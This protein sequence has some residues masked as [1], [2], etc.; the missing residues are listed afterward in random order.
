ML[1]LD[2]DIPCAPPMDVPPAPQMSDD[3]LTQ[4]AVATANKLRKLHWDTLGGE[5][6]ARGTIFES[7][8]TQLDQTTVE[9]IEKLFAAVVPQQ[10]SEEEPVV[11][12]VELIDRRR[13]QNVS[14]ALRGLK[15]SADDIIR[16]ILECDLQL[17][18]V[19]RLQQL[20]A[21]LPDAVEAKQI[22]AYSGAAERLGPAEH[23]MLAVTAIP[24]CAVRLQL[25]LLAATFEDAVSQLSAHCHTMTDACEAVRS[26]DR[27]A[28]AMQGVLAV[29]GLMSGKRAAGFKLSSL[30]KL[31]ALKSQQQQ[32]AQF[33]LLDFIVEREVSR[34][35]ADELIP[36]RADR[37]FF[38]SLGR[39]KAALGR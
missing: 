34:A 37:L 10:R 39:G 25:L 9:A 15:T 1:G 12:A 24:R 8:D 19:E 38:E 27:L 20:I 35:Q 11:R 13:A 23:F 7:L 6:E 30:D 18:S 16:A 17:L 21:C 31:H 32:H 29:G 4:P 22:K 33:S 14:I 26:S 2:S 5:A 28:A 36:P 3:G